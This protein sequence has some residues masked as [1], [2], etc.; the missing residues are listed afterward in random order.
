MQR[1]AFVSYGC[2]VNRAELDTLIANLPRYGAIYEYKPEEAD[3]VIV[4][5]CAVTER[6]QNE[7][8]RGLTQ[9]RK[10]N[11]SGKIV[12]TGCMAELLK[13]DNDADINADIIVLNNDK[14]RILERMLGRKSGGI[15]AVLPIRTKTRAFLKIQDGCSCAC[16]YCIIPSLRGASRSKSANETIDELRTLLKSGYKEIVL[17]GIHIGLYG[18][19]L[20]SEDNLCSLLRQIIALEGD[21]RVRL[22]S[23][24]VNEI[25]DELVDVMASS[26]GKLAPHVHISLQSGSNEVLMAMNRKYT[27][28]EA[29]HAVHELRAGVSDVCIGLDI[30]TGFPS[31]TDR[32]F[33]ETKELL[34]E[35]KPEYMHIF[36]FSA[37]PGTTAADM[38][39]QV[40]QTVRLERASM[41]RELAKKYK[42]DAN[43]RQAGKLV[44]VLSEGGGKGH[45][46]NFFL[47]QLPQETEKNLFI[48]GIL[49]YDNDNERLYLDV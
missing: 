4:N 20:P 30:I 27:T 8:R 21:F 2:K 33:N 1:V 48:E 3:I 22:T 36:P 5:T 45:T 42:D 47:V 15:P 12:A 38:A 14:E 31:E 7:C 24:H 17:T 23:M 18:A 9:L 34:A 32:L 41:L 43:K 13:T 16:S 29:L 28:E 39:G 40:P 46:D 26:A 35:I 44:R 19:D 49:R 25:T 6:A 37:R 11:A 10:S